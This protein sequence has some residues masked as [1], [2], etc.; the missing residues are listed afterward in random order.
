MFSI[1]NIN[2]GSKSIG[3]IDYPTYPTSPTV[4]QFNNSSL[5][6]SRKLQY[7]GITL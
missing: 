6:E 5:T 7:T 2:E 3:T 4:S 1:N